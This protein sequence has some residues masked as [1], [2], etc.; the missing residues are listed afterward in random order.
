MKAAQYSDMG[1]YLR[2]VR[3]SLDIKIE[4]AATTLHI[5]P[6]YLQDLEAGDLS[7]MPGKVYIRGY[8]KNYAEFLKLNSNEVL[9]E[10]EKL[11]GNATTSNGG[12]QQFFIPEKSTIYNN[13]PSERTMWF[14]FAS[15]LI[16]YSYWYF[17]VYDNIPTDRGLSHLASPQQIMNG[18]KQDWESC[19]NSGRTSCFMQLHEGNIVPQ[20]ETL[21]GKPSAT[22]TATAATNVSKPEDKPA[23]KPEEKAKKPSA[24]DEE[25]E[26]DDDE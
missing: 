11:F 14:S 10:Y 3:E 18:M 25:D 1:K 5:R 19:L 20:G 13:I 4:D 7:N 23:V 21:I 15:L 22:D 17:G 6:K 26:E 24:N 9:S 12:R 8:I 2:D 16:L